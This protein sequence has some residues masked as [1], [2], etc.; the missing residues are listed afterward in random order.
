MSSTQSR[1]ETVG[2]ISLNVEFRGRLPYSDFLPHSEN[3]GSAQCVVNPNHG[4]CAKHIEKKYPSTDIFRAP[5]TSSFQP[6]FAG[7][8]WVEALK[9]KGLYYS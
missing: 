1:C 3:R 4:W 7:R 8:F 6:G 2:R 5:V 9:L